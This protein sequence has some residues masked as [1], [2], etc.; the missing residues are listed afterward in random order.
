MND[1]M[2]RRQ[3]YRECERA[4]RRPV[5]LHA[6][7]QLL[8]G[9]LTVLTADVL[10]RFADAAFR[11]ELAVG[12]HD[13]AMLALCILATV[14]IAPLFGLLGNFSMLKRSLIHDNLVFKR[15]LRK[16][17]QS[18]A[19]M[20]AG[21]LQYELEDA[22]NTLRIYWVV[23]VSNGI[24]QPASWAYLLY[25]AGGIS[26]ALTGV[27]I[28]VALMQLLAPMLLRRRLSNFDAMDK[29]NQAERRAYESELTKKPHLIKLWGLKIP[30]LN[31]LEGLYRAAYTSTDSQRIA[32][33]AMTDHAPAFLSGFGSLVVFAAGALMVARH[34]ISPGDLAAMLVYLTVTKTLLGQISDMIRD[35]PLMQ[36]AAGRLCEI[37]R[38]QEPQSG[39]ILPHFVALAGRDVSFAYPNKPVLDRVNFSINKGDKVRIVGAN[40]AGKSTLLK[41]VGAQ[42]PG[43]EGEIT[44][45]GVDLRSI[46]PA[47]WR[48]H[49]AFAPQDPYIFT[50]SVEEN[51]A[52]GDPLVT[53]DMIR[54]C[55]TALG[56]DHL[57]GR[58]LSP[59]SKL[60]GGERQKLS[61][62]RALLRDAEICIF[63]EPTN[64]LD[65]KSLKTLAERLK[66][67]D[68]TVILIT[69]DSALDDIV[70]RQIP[71][72]PNHNAVEPD[73]NG[74]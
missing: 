18:V 4:M 34:D 56:I 10:G 69:H 25:N 46:A 24:A 68:K 48:K 9:L 19:M 73:S 32:T 2:L 59:Q 52:L 64:H 23:I 20:D 41:I 47:Q 26:P 17:P 39:E 50:A 60:S 13:A 7:T 31:R 55:L 16:E 42:L 70:N 22:P 57:L 63:D 14:A 30:F 37:Y 6:L 21:A 33:K 62:A 3:V 45:N 65:K 38:D 8:T 58:M 12:L 43:Y 11:G 74:V 71:I 28:G 54:H 51:V 27:M 49:I 61:I 72:E 44:V 5:I 36:N 67:T 40:G 1:K 35:H 15:F 66:N 53:D 29:R